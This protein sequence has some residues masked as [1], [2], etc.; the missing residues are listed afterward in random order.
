MLKS[1]FPSSAVVIEK[2]GHIDICT[3]AVDKISL[4]KTQFF[5]VVGYTLKEVSSGSTII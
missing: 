4:T 2:L 3:S 5:Q 1:I